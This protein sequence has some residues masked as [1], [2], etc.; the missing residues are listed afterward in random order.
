MNAEK[1]RE[2]IKRRI[3]L[4]AND[5]SATMEC[6]SIETDILTVNITESIEF[7]KTCSEEEFYWLSEVFDE[8]IDKTQSQELFLAM[9]DRNALLENQEYRESIETDLSYARASLIE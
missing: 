5:D 6:W 3:A 7:L 4:D 1:L 2:T 8:V 9:C